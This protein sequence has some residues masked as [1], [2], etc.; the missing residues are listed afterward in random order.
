MGKQQPVTITASFI[1]PK[2]LK[3]ILIAED[4][5]PMA[6]ALELKLTAAGFLVQTTA[7]GRE[8]L[9][10]LK[11]SSYDLLLLDLVIPEVDG[12]VILQEIKAYSKRLPVIV[13]SNLS[14]GEDVAKA[15]ALGADYYFI[16]SDSTLTRIIEEVKRILKV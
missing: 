16:K 5:R 6:R 7:S 11:E 3:K 15:K 1:M 2:Q 9:R 8:A 4:E 10:L 14:Q 13:L 12:F